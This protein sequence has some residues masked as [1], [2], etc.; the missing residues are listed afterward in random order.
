[1]KIWFL[2]LLIPFLFLLPHWVPDGRLIKNSQIKR[3]S[4]GDAPI[5]ELLKNYKA[6]NGLDGKILTDYQY[7]GFLPDLE[8]YYEYSPSDQ[9]EFIEKFND[10]EV[11]YALVKDHWWSSEVHEYIFTLINEKKIQLI[12]ELEP[13]IGNGRYYFVTTCHG[14]CK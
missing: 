2:L 9:S 8:T 7:L 11:G 6:E 3:M 1:M 14:V 10:P 4:I 5:N 13:S 12:F